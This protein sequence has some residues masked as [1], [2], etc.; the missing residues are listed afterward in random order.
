MAIG[1]MAALT[2]IAKSMGLE[3]EPIKGESLLHKEA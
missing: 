1:R 2:A 3:A